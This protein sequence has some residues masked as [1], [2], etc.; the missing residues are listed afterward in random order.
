MSRAVSAFPSATARGAIE[1]CW[2]TVLVVLPL[3]PNARN[4]AATTTPP[5]R[6]AANGEAT[7]LFMRPGSVVGARE[8]ELKVDRPAL[9]RRGARLGALAQARELA[10][11]GLDIRGAHERLAD[12]HGVDAD[13]IELLELRA[14]GVA[15]LGHD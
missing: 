2:T 15:R 1:D 7:V 13:P 4:A 9:G 14:G 6:A 5:T 10:A 3:A 11:G 8:A 12:Q